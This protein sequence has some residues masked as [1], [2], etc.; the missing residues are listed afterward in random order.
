MLVVSV[1]QLD[2]EGEVCR[3]VM[4]IGVR[5]LAQE[6]VDAMIERRGRA[7]KLAALS[8]ELFEQPRIGK[9]MTPGFQLVQKPHIVHPC[10]ASIWGIPVDSRVGAD[11]RSPFSLA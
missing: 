5:Q 6:R 4:E 10:P 3:D 7:P 1:P 11:Y 9:R 2:A 8:A